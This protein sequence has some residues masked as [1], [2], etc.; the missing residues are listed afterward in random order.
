VCLGPSPDWENENISAGIKGEQVA[1]RNLVVHHRHVAEP[2]VSLAAI[3]LL[4][5]DGKPLRLERITNRPVEESVL[6]RDAQWKLEAT[7]AAVTVLVPALERLERE[8]SSLQVRA[9]IRSFW[10]MGV[11]LAALAHCPRPIASFNAAS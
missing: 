2:L 3:K 8:S 11:A 9:H 5:E 6:A 4:P 1:R 10:G 7:P